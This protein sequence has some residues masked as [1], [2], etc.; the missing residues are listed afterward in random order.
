MCGRFA[1]TIHE[2]DLMERFNVVSNEKVKPRYNIAPTQDAAVILSQSPGEISMLKWG[3]VP[4][5]AS[6]A[7]VGQKMINARAETV[8]EKP[9]FKQPFE[10]K[11]CL[12]L[13]DSFYEW[14][15]VGTRKAP[16]RVMMKS[17]E[18]FAFAGIW[19]EWH[20]G[21]RT[22]SIITVEPNDLVIPIH[23]RM[24]AILPRASERDYL[25]A[26]VDDAKAMLRP[27]P[28]E[29]MKAYALTSAINSPENDSPEVIRP[30]T[31][32]SSF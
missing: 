20:G 13:A 30:A 27:F 18:A 29:L 2:P 6:D 31:T 5:W 23:N 1:L 26:N 25:S 7:R 17:A 19:D 12:V 16:Y 14:K 15:K 21:L 3:L 10:R 32:L 8:D 24:P 11:R 28:S 22:F 9:A 4:H